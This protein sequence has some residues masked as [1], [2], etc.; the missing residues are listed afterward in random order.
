MPKNITRQEKLNSCN[1]FLCGTIFLCF[2]ART[3]RKWRAGHSVRCFPHF[4]TEKSKPP[5]GWLEGGLHGLRD[6]FRAALL[7]WQHFPCL[8]T[9]VRHCFDWFFFNNS[10]N[11]MCIGVWVSDSL[12]LSDG[13]VWTTMWV[14]G[15]FQPSRCFNHKPSLQPLDWF[16]KGKK[17]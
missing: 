11:F 3:T 4:Y 8:S 16:I 14:L 7:Q 1:C 13:Q 9:L 12:K 6:C 10:F 5:K 15:M 17:S 2:S